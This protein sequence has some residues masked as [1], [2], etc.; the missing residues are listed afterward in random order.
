M[1][2]VQSLGFSAWGLGLI[3]AV[4]LEPVSGLDYWQEVSSRLWLRLL[5]RKLLVG[6]SGT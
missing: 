4:Q 1:F 6:L 5:K 2:R 3:I